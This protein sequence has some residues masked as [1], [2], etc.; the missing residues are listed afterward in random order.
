M[1]LL[2]G[3]TSQSFNNAP[4]SY[5]SIVQRFSCINDGVATDSCCG[6]AGFLIAA[7]HQMLLKNEDEN[8]QLVSNISDNVSIKHK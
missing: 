2:N 5:R 8:E 1:G 4:C 3:A 6:T 7:V